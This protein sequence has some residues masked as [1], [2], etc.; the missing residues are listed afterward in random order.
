MFRVLI[1]SLTLLASSVAVAQVPSQSGGKNMVEMQVADEF[2]AIAME[3][4]K[5]L[6][7]ADV[8]QFLKA[9]DDFVSWAESDV[10]NRAAFHAM[11]ADARRAKME[12][13]VS[14]G[15]GHKNGMAILFGRIEFAN[16]MSQPGERDKLKK[17]Y[18]ESQAQKAM[19]ESKLKELPPQMQSQMKSQLTGALEMLESGANYPDE[20][21]AVYKKNQAKLD[22]AIK[23]LEDLDKD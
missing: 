2:M 18:A 7:E 12:E 19:M 23:R 14:A 21:I 6:T 4:S 9:V 17:Q 11:S 20:A 5:P 16:K 1:F 3:A 13:M 15:Q 8:K 10:K 22:A